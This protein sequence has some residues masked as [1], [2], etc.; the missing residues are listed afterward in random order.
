MM[1][2]D[3]PAALDRFRAAVLADEALQLELVAFHNPAP[4]VVCA[5]E[6]AAGLGITLDPATLDPQTQYDPLGLYRLLDRPVQVDGWLPRHWLP[7]ELLEIDGTLSVGWLHF[8]GAPLTEP[9]FEG[10]IRHIQSRPFNRLF[11]FATPINLFVSR[12]EDAPPIDGFIFHMSRCGST[13]VAQMLA[14]VP[15][16]I[17]VSEAP[18]LDALILRVASGAAPLGSIKAMVD[19]LTRNRTG[20]G[21][22]RFIKLDSWHALAMPLLRRVFPE[23]PW[24][25]LYRNP[26]E[27]LVSQ[28]RMAGV[29]A[30]PGV[31]PVSLFGVSGA[32]TMPYADYCA[33]LLGRLCTV[34]L[35]EL[36]H[37]RG[38][39]VN[40]RD[41]PDAA[42]SSI[43]PHF[44]LQPDGAEQLMI[45]AAGLRDAKAPNRRFTSDTAA[46]HAETTTAIQETADR[47]VSVVY[48]QLESARLVG[49]GQRQRVGD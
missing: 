10:S 48:A 2:T 25:F 28:Q 24:V 31:V 7:T 5:V 15:D 21:R 30:L 13:L 8:A 49:P 18:V 19:A 27:V 26:V 6:R 20:Q 40:Y 12:A 46:K 43:L 17:V 36:P 39:L 16:H 47:Y 4:F 14:A 22:H 35:A 34:V 32:E 38:L 37:G 23:I 9:F 42:S 29:Q 1:I 11:R 33:W 45:E 41:L 44:G 3:Q